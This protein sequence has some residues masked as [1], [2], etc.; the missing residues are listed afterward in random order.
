MHVKI[1]DQ[2]SPVPLFFDK[3]FRYEKLMS[4]KL[5]SY[6]LIINWIEYWINGSASFQ[7]GNWG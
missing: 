3:I 1:L 6:N 5:D 2:H 7:M 4:K